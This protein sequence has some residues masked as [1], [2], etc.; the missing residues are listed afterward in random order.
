[1]PAPRP[2]SR[3]RLILASGSP[4]R[5]GLLNRINLH[6]ETVSPDIDESPRHGETSGE[7]ALRLAC[8][9]AEKISLQ[10]PTAIVIGSDQV[11]ALGSQFMGK[12]GDHKTAVGQLTMCS[13]KAVVI[14]TAVCVRHNEAHFEETHIDLTTVNFR[15]LSAEEIEAYVYADKPWDC[16]GSFKSEGLGAALFKSIDNQDPSAIIGLPLIWLAACLQRAGLNI[17]AQ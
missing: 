13:G 4:Y 16:A 2:N 1:M 15:T 9:K 8:A 17:L 7:L 6:F 5:K 12:P 11:A 14:Y 3:P 10:H